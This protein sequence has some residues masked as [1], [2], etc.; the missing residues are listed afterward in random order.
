VSKGIADSEP[1]GINGDCFWVLGMYDDGGHGLTALELHGL[2]ARENE[3]MGWPVPTPGQVGR[4][5]RLLAR[6]RTPLTE[7]LAGRWLLT[8]HAHDQ[9][10]QWAGEEEEPARVPCGL[11]WPA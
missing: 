6:R 11:G 4:S 3:S 5:L 1:D 10:R 9:I 7:R 8:A 2:I